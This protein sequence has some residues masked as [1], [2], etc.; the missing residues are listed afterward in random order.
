MSNFAAA[1]GNVYFQQHYKRGAIIR[2]NMECDDPRRDMRNKFGVVLNKNTS[3]DEVLLAIT[4][5]NQAPFASGYLENDIL[6]IDAGA[7]A[8]FDKPTILNLREIRPEPVEHLKELCR[9][10]QLTFHG[11]MSESDL[12]VVLQKVANSKLIEGKYKKRIV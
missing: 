6:R 3:E 10:G 9:S 1:L 2:F 11:E 12:P 7:Y 8:C 4:T 5:S